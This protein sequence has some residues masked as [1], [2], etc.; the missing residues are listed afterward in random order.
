MR[1]RFQK[2]MPR[3]AAAGRRAGTRNRSSQD[4][5]QFCREVLET[6]EF[7]RK[8]QLYFE[9]TPLDQMDPRLLALAFTYGYGKPRERMES[10]GPENGQE[11]AQVLFYLPS[12]QRDPNL[13][14]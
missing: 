4:I 9:Q 5:G 2:G 11:R 6:P 1:H 12:N 3:P 10:R 8:W 7:R 14:G 13:L